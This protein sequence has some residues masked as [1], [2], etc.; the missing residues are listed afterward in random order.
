MRRTLPTVLVVVALALSACQVEGPGSTEAPGATEAPGTTEPPTTEAPETTAPPT[1]T[2]APTES[3]DPPTDTT[4]PAG[5]E[6]DAA[7]DGDGVPVW[8][9]VL[10]GAALVALGAVLFRPRRPRGPD[11]ATAPAPPPAP[12]PVIDPALKSDAYAEARWLADRLTP[13]LAEFKAQVDAGTVPTPPDTD[14]RRQALDALAGRT[15]A[16][17]NALYQAEAS[18]TTDTARTVVRASIDALDGLRSAFDG[19]VLA[20]AA[21]DPSAARSQL[22]TARQVVA[23]SLETLRSL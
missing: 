14:A 7:E 16:A 3:T 1:E 11:V 18:A 17:S 23:A 21:G 15:A 8:V 20:A 4:V 12:A 2:T 6:D 10:G 13:D 9:W 22:D 5:G 19:Y